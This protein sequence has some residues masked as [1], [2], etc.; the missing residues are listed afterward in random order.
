MSHPN[1][2]IARCK[3]QTAKSW[4]EAPGYSEL[5]RFSSLQQQFTQASRKQSELQNSYKILWSWNDCT[6]DHSQFKKYIMEGVLRKT[7]SAVS[8]FQRDVFPRR[9]FIVDFTQAVI[10]I[11][12]HQEFGGENMYWNKRL[13]RYVAKPFHQLLEE[14]EKKIVLPFRSVIDVHQPST[15]L[16]QSVVPK[17]WE[18]PFSLHTIDRRYVLFAPSNDE[19]KMWMAGFEYVI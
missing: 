4:D 16:P 12:H 6:F 10:Y 15:C 9:Y 7:V 17:D 8:V 5:N 3:K 19:R 18:Y 2:N 13:N 11:T 14:D 1:A